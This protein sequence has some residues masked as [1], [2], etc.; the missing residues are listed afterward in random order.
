MSLSSSHRVNDTNKVKL[1]YKAIYLC[2]MHFF[3]LREAVG[4]K[5]SLV[6]T[7]PVV[8]NSTLNIHFERTT[9]RPF[10]KS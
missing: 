9:L 6:A 2:I 10:N 1:D 4:N 3:F 5:T 7:V 8:A